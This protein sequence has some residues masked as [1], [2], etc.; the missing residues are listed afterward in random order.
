MSGK[1]KKV[2]DDGAL[3]RCQECG[4]MYTHSEVIYFVHLT[5]ENKNCIL[6]KNCVDEEWLKDAVCVGKI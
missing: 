3:W 1:Y 5:D 2:R 6:C 4:K